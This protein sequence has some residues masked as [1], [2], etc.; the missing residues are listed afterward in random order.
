MYHF[1]NINIYLLVI[2][3]SIPRL[4]I[5]NILNDERTFDLNTIYTNIIIKHY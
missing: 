2:I 5:R 3:I 4:L 1:N